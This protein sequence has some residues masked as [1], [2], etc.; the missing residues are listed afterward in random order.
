MGLLAAAVVGTCFF[1]QNQQRVTARLLGLGAAGFVGLAVAGIAS[2]PLGRVGMS[3]LLVGGL[4]FAVP[5]AVH[6]ALE[7]GRLLVGWTGKRW[8]AVAPKRPSTP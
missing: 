3:H 6:G 2:E 1:N 8:R 5:L 4:L 7:S